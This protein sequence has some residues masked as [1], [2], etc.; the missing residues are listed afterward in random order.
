[1]AVSIKQTDTAATHGAAAAC[2]GAT[3]A[4]T[5]QTSQAEVGGTAGTGT[6]TFTITKN[7]TEAGFFVET[8]ALD[9][10]TW[11]S[12]TWTVRLNVTTA[13]SNVDLED[14]YICRVNS[15]GVSQ[16]TIGSNTGI[17]ESLGTTGVKSWTVSGS[18]QTPSAGDRVYIVYVFQNNHAHSN[19]SISVLANQDIDSPFTATSTDVTVTP[20]VL[21]STFSVQTPTVSTVQ[22]RTVTPVALVGTLSEQAPTVTAATNVTITP[23]V[24][25]GAFS[26]QSPTV[27]TAGNVTVTPNALSLTWNL[28]A[29]TVSTVQNATVT[30]AAISVTGNLP[31]PTVSTPG[32]RTTYYVNTASTAGGDGTTNNTSGTTRAFASLNEAESNLQADL[33][34]N[35]DA[36]EIICSGS[37]ADTTAVNFSGWTV[38]ATYNILIRTDSTLSNSRHSGTYS[39]SHYRLEAYH[40]ALDLNQKFC[41]V[42]GL[43]VKAG[44]INGNDFYGIDLNANGGTI[45]NCIVTLDRGSIS[46]EGNGCW[47]IYGG[48]T[49]TENVYLLNN[50][51]YG[52]YIS[53]KT[54][55]GIWTQGYDTG[56]NGYYYHNTVYDCDRGMLDGYGGNTHA[57]NNVSDNNNTDN[58][59]GTFHSSSDYN[60]SGDTSS[61]GGTNDSTSV[62][63]TFTNAGSGD[64]STSDTDLVISNNLY[65]DSNLPV[66]EDVAENVRPSSGDV[67]AG[68]WEGT[69]STDV[70]VSATVLTATLATQAP[71]VS[72]VQNATVTPAAL[73]GTFSDQTPSVST[74]TNA[75]L[76][77]SELSGTF[78]LPAPAV[79]TTTNVNTSPSTLSIVAS[80]QAPTANTTSNVSVAPIA[81]SA[82]FSEQTP[83]VT[84]A[85][86]VTVSPNVLTSTLSEQAPTVA[87]TTNV[88]VEP[89]VLSGSFS[90][91]TPTLSTTANVAISADVVSGTFSEQTPSV[92]S[93][94][95]VTVTPDVQT[96]VFSEQA[97]TVNTTSNVSLSPSTLSIV[98]S[99]QAP[100]VS[101]GGSVTVGVEAI[102]LTSSLPGSTVSTV[103]NVSIPLTA[104][105][106]SFTGQV[107]S[108]SAGGAIT[109][110]PGSQ[111]VAFS[112]L[113]PTVTTT[114]NVSLA[115]N[116]LEIASSE[117]TPSVGASGNVEVALGALNLTCTQPSPSVKIG[118]EI[119]TSPLV[120]NFS[121]PNPT[122][123][124]TANVSV[125]SDIL[126]LT[127]TILNPDLSIAGVAGTPSRY[128]KTRN[129]KFLIETEGRVIQ[130][131]S[132]ERE[133]VV[134]R[135]DT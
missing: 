53:G 129:R 21:T 7:A 42:D 4:A 44:G 96:S 81:L 132:E 45:K 69:G 15:S 61:A 131:D 47:G 89:G 121:L 71:T 87:T 8:T 84:A 77:P 51:V 20:G 70:S 9:D 90:E 25:S 63:I 76:S 32:A 60:I 13:D 86:N 40:T 31:S 28:P 37:T 35:T 68:A 67:Y 41:E 34:T 104:V 24:L 50:I 36:I 95:A 55:W 111:S 74:S 64:F 58:Y 78:S 10:Y 117:L 122:T 125:S 75:S 114:K 102:S 54:S 92:S 83:G 109:T 6:K 130:R 18:A 127:S 23:S 103:E 124:T 39:T 106:S 3:L 99:A 113:D 119:D 22:N 29:P 120:S 56:K 19:K 73:V 26:E 33:V 98:A 2:S 12:G 123:H 17:N 5:T 115:Q 135:G 59:G 128:F 27:T 1:M 30:P 116:V 133:Y 49:S 118:A 46:T 94:G 11:D 93:S 97:P 107:P 43:Q 16:A 100:G 14:I 48:V 134:G 108:V 105:S 38:N 66:E 80:E 126:N 65:S 85:E 72:T 52:F 57:K 82:T 62:T 101:V 110:T 79:S 88:T 112:A 91:Q